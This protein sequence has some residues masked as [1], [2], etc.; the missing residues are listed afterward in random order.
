M[1][2]LNLLGDGCEGGHD[3]LKLPYFLILNITVANIDAHLWINLIIDLI[4][5]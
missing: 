5:Y 1:S 4:K 2:N 3:G